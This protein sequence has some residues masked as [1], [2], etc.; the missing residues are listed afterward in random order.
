MKKAIWVFGLILGL[1][2]AFAGFARADIALLPGNSINIGG[3]VITCGAFD[4]FVTGYGVDGGLIN[5]RPR[6]GTAQGAVALAQLDA[7]QRC[8]GQINSGFEVLVRNCGQ[9]RLSNGFQV[10]ACSATVRAS[11]VR[12]E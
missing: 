2:L 11:C 4:P 5:G 6:S 1:G 12:V 3:N 8:A 7:R 10:T 9:V